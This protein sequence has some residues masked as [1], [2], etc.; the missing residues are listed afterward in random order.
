[1]TPSLRRSGPHAG[2]DLSEA[3]EAPASSRRRFEDTGSE[4]ISVGP[5]EQISAT[6]FA[7]TVEVLG[8]GLEVLEGVDGM[9][10]QVGGT[11]SMTHTVEITFLTGSEKD[12]GEFREKR[13]FKE[14]ELFDGAKLAGR[15]E[16]LRVTWVTA[17]AQTPKALRLRIFKQPLRI[18]ETAPPRPMGVP[19]IDYFD[20]LVFQAGI[21]DAAKVIYDDSVAVP[22]QYLYRDANPALGTG[23][24]GDFRHGP[25][26]SMKRKLIGRIVIPQ[27]LATAMYS[28]TVESEDSG[29]I[30]RVL[31]LFEAKARPSNNPL[32]YD[33][34]SHQVIAFTQIHATADDGNGSIGSGM[35]VPGKIRI[36][37]VTNALAQAALSN[38]TVWLSFLGVG[39]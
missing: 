19:I 26:F 31:A 16:R 15:F 1:M 25:H 9:T 20:G 38:C 14:Y 33:V 37:L 28:A 35:W 24:G 4:I 34:G 39:G 13:T 27:L 7:A 2:L 23:L 3:P 21:T 10:L 36:R 22:Q 32:D 8:Y 11:G 30:W 29:G 18:I 5:I 17:T 12:V 6:T